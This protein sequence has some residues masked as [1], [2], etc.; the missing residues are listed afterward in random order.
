MQEPKGINEMA[1]R[2]QLLQLNGQHAAAATGQ[3]SNIST[4]C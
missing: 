3:S 4:T 2:S 1:D